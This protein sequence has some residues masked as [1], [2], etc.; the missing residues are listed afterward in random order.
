[1]TAIEKW[2]CYPQLREGGKSHRGS[3]ATWR[4]SSVCHEKV[5]EGQD[6]WARGSL[7]CLWEGTGEAGQTGWDG[8]VWIIS[9]GSGDWCPPLADPGWW[10]MECESPNKSGVGW[11]GEALDWSAYIWKAILQ[12]SCLLF[13]GIGWPGRGSLSRIDQQGPKC[14]N[15][16]IQNTKVKDLVNTGRIR[17]QEN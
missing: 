16:K 1:M 15:I 14:Q 10:I 6:L 8:L 17:L 7:C 13:P 3:E 2:V 5:G 12:V 11:W 9:V 4:G